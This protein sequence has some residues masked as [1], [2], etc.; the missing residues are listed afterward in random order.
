MAAGSRPAP[1]PPGKELSR[2][3]SDSPRGPYHKPVPTPVRRRIRWRG[4]DRDARLTARLVAVFVAPLAVLALASTALA[5]PALPA[6]SADL[7]PTP[8]PS[9]CVGGVLLCGPQVTLP[10][11]PPVPLPSVCVGPACTG[12]I[13]GTATP[14]STP[15]PPS[16]RDTSAPGSPSPQGGP[17]P[18]GNG[19]GPVA[20]AL[21]APPGVG[22]VPA[23]VSAP[24][25]DS[26]NPDAFATVLSLS[27]RDGLGAARYHVWPTLLAI[28][29]LLWTA[30]AGYAWS[31][32]AGP[33]TPARPG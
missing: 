20:A 18:G 6:A 27:L 12:T 3:R 30:I 32:Q 13:V 24:V 23:L 16:P 8:L 9:V 19:P 14:T 26:L 33:R 7:L 11:S 5:R 25:Q 4:G 10:T 29:L 28:Q 21:P 17:L 22:L 1:N 15:P 2:P 31:R